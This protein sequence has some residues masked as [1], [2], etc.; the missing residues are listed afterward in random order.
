MKNAFIWIAVGLIIVAFLV[1][2]SKGDAEEK[3]TAAEDQGAV[4][5]LKFKIYT[6]DS[7]RN[8]GILAV[9]AKE[10]P[11]TQTT[12]AGRDARNAMLHSAFHSYDSQA[13]LDSIA[14]DIYNAKSVFDD[15]ES[16][17]YAALA[18]ITSLMDLYAVNAM[19]FSIVVKRL[20]EKKVAF[21][22]GLANID[23]IFGVQPTNVIDFLHS[24]LNNKEKL[25][26]LKYLEAMPMFIHAGKKYFLPK[27]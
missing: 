11:G 10:F 18:R 7:G 17:A 20:N 9:I 22:F 25:K 6:T 26:C 4:D 24:F 27:T 2:S 12:Q 3:E 8:A 15:D 5:F 14:A 19:S 21:T 16:K 23:P 1:G 13:T